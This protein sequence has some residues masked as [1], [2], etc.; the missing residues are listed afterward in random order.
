MPARLSRRKL[1]DYTAQQLLA[2]H[3]EV[4]DE[5]A[6]L[7]VSQ[8]RQRELELLVRDIEGSLAARGTVVVTVESARK[9]DEAARRAITKLVQDSA[10][11]AARIELKEIVQPEL[12]GGVKITTPTQKLDASL[13]KKLTDLRT[14]H[15]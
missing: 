15:K 4:I 14:R 11:N 2:G 10:D 7:L 13:A 1:A 6:A 5:V 9:L 8:G 3:A 12:L